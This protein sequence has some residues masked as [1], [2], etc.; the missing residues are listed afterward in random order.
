[1]CN[2][3]KKLFSGKCCCHKG[4]ACCQENKVEPAS[5]APKMP[6]TSSPDEPKT[7]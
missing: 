7:E 2:W 6:E 4:E 5:E 1:M 3:F